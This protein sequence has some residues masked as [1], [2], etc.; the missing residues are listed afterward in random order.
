MPQQRLPDPTD[1]NPAAA[2]LPLTLNARLASALADE[3]R[4]RRV[5][6]LPLKAELMRDLGLGTL[7]QASAWMVD[8]SGTFAAVAAEFIAAQ[9][10]E[11]AAADGWRETVEELVRAH[12]HA[13]ECRQ[14]IEGEDADTSP[15]AQQRYTASLILLESSYLRASKRLGLLPCPV[16]SGVD[17]EGLASTQP[18]A[19]NLRSLANDPETAIRA[20]GVEWAGRCAQ[21]ALQALAAKDAQV[22]L[23]PVDLRGIDAGTAAEWAQMPG[24]G[25]AQLVQVADVPRLVSRLLGTRRFASLEPL[26][27]PYHQVQSQYEASGRPGVTVTCDL[28]VRNVGTETQFELA[29][30]DHHSKSGRTISAHAGL[31]LAPPAARAMALAIAPELAVDHIQA[32]QP[33]VTYGEIDP[34]AI[35]GGIPLTDG[36]KRLATLLIQALGPRHPAM[37]DFMALLFRAQAPA[38]VG[39]QEGKGA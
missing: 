2:G 20:F 14:A 25:T 21:T 16:D 30:A 19:V 6:S 10:T 3:L 12:D 15:A 27:R 35:V 33:D 38:A 36:D 5:T 1:A 39:A 32:P 4:R 18:L 13:R 26:T 34:S 22:P 9:S 28:Q 11:Q 29:I 24:A 8:T 23:S 31:Q 7:E 37:D 17:P